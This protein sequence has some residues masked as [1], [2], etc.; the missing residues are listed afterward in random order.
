MPRQ[1]EE[2]PSLIREEGPAVQRKR[3]KSSEKT[4]GVA[5]RGL[6]RG[7]GRSSKLQSSGPNNG[8][9]P[10]DHTGR[11]DHEPQGHT[12]KADPSGVVA[13]CV[14]AGDERAGPLDPSHIARAGADDLTE[15]RP[16]LPR[17]GR[18]TRDKRPYRAW[19]N[20]PAFRR[21]AEPRSHGTASA[22]GIEAGNGVLGG[23]QRG[24]AGPA[25][26]R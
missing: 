20:F 4:G 24:R 17:T 16:G 13:A 21:R 15:H 18:L 8:W 26:R 1:P 2:I 12:I 7:L 19:R 11:P 5:K 3:A 22:P 14:G 6:F 9:R 25:D 10:R 23:G